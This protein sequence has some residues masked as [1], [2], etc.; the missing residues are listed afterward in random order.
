MNRAKVLLVMILFYAITANSS[1]REVV[2][3][4]VAEEGDATVEIALTRFDLSDQTLTLTYEITN[5]SE[6]DVWVCEGV[7]VLDS[8]DPQDYDVYLEQDGTLMLRRRLEVVDEVACYAARAYRGTYVRL[9]PGQKR[10]ESL[11]LTVPIEPYH[12]LSFHAVRGFDYVTRMVVEVGLFEGDLPG[13]IRQICEIAERLNCERVYYS[14]IDVENVEL[15]DEY[16][17]GLIVANSFGGL[18]GFDE[19]FPEGSNQ[20]VIPHMWPVRLGE[21]GLRMTIDGVFLPYAGE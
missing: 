10:T 13:R 15:Y 17:G 1:N 12:I 16:F 7:R 9:R 2:G 3:H 11:S 14:D 8:A 5:G 20:I 6:Q 21:R 19:A 4:S 18:A